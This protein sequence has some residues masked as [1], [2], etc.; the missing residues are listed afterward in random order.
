MKFE[1]SYF[2]GGVES[3]YTDYEL[4]R[5]P[6]LCEELISAVNIQ[7]KDKILDIGCATGALLWEF[8]KKGYTKI[9]GTDIS[10]WAI[11]IG[12]KRFK[13]KKILEHYNRNLLTEQKWN[14]IIMLDVL[15][16]MDS[17]EIHRIFEHL[18]QNRNNRKIIVRIPVSA[19]EGEDFALEISKRD[20]THIQVHSKE[21]W[22][23]LFNKYGYRLEHRFIKSN[24]YDSEGVLAG[25]FS[26]G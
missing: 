13:M 15:E 9:K 26:Y 24:I 19:K 21:W 1:K 3:N 12:R 14:I 6:I 10:M 22:E 11:N 16:H 20:K 18:E 17:D 5:Y 8:K 7:K 4:K 2:K 25:V 23:N